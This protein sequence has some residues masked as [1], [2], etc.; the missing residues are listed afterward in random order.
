MPIRQREGPFNITVMSHG[1]VCEFNVQIPTWL[2][3]KCASE[4]NHTKIDNNN[5]LS[6]KWATKLF[7]QWQ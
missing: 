3:N 7:K 2:S 1:N 5:E 4:T 6:Q